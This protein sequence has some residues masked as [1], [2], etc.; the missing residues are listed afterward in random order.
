MKYLLK[1]LMVTVVAAGL[2]PLYGVHMGLKYRCEA[3]DGQVESY[4]KELNACVVSACE[5]SYRDAQRIAELE[6]ELK[7]LTAEK[8]DATVFKPA[9]VTHVAEAKTK[10]SP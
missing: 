4:D 8:A 6:A 3:L 1:I 2:I 10:K 9:T 7:A 5:R